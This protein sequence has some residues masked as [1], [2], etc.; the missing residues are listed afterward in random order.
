MSV[1]GIAIATVSP[2]FPFGIRNY[3]EGVVF[4]FILL[5]HSTV[6]SGN[7][8]CRKYSEIKV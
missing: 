7:L 4:F 3:S 1:R 2:M 8:R 6:K 5:L